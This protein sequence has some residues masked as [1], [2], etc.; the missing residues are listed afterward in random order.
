[1]QKNLTSILAQERIVSQFQLLASV[2]TT[3]IIT[4][5]MAFPRAIGK[6]R[7]AETSGALADFFVASVASYFRPSCTCVDVVFNRYKENS[8]KSN[9]QENRQP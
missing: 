9:V 1:M 4:D 8:I 6:P 7:Q 5:E 2:E 3:G